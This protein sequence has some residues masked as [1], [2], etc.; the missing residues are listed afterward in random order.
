MRF[1][2]H[3]SILTRVEK[4]QT[5]L[6]R[7]E[8]PKGGKKMTKLL[9]ILFFAAFCLGCAEKIDGSSEN[10]FKSS[11]EAIEKEM[12]NERKDKFQEA[13]A[14]FQ[15]TEKDYLQALDGQTA[16]DVISA[17]EKAMRDQ[18]KKEA[19]LK[20]SQEADKRYL[21]YPIE[22]SQM[23]LPLTCPGITMNM[24]G[25]PAVVAEIPIFE[26][27][28]TPRTLF[29]SDNLISEPTRGIQYSFEKGDFRI[30]NCGTESRSY[31]VSKV[32]LEKIETNE[33]TKQY[34]LTVYAPIDENGEKTK[35]D[36]ELYKF[37]LAFTPDHDD[38]RNYLKYLRVK[39]MLNGH[40]VEKS[41]QL[42]SNDEDIMLGFLQFADA[43][44][45]LEKITGKRG[46]QSLSRKSIENPLESSNNDEAASKPDDTF[47]NLVSD[48]KSI[49]ASSFRKK[50]PVENL[51]DG[52]PDTAWNSNGDEELGG[53]SITVV[54]REK[55]LVDSITLRAWEKVSQKGV[56]L[57]S[58]NARI[59]RFS[60]KFDDGSELPVK[61][62]EDQRAIELS[63]IQ[64]TTKS[65]IIEISETW[66]GEKWQDICLSELS[67][68]GGDVNQ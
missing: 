13:I 26:K 8:I 28:V 32:L 17:L 59:R 60:L 2:V 16:D 11:V 10:T 12:D 50:H 27:R 20:S 35:A 66:P 15:I 14:F 19:E 24:T 68:S 37:R 55:R 25:I 62:D 7:Q 9:P 52:N 5:D 42:L 54:F 56:D 23:D 3:D 18:E 31:P 48:I 51:L 58:A 65:I 22:F 36:N 53:S 64:K 46:K 6:H 4:L 33:E 49:E 43:L 1:S 30:D 67:I 45:N 47:R 41:S 29:H 57:F 44:F 34:F 39:N 21:D 63:D 40:V 61:T 38:K